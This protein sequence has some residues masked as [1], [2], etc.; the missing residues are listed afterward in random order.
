MFST[1]VDSYLILEHVNYPFFFL[2][3]L[4]VN[5]DLHIKFKCFFFF[6]WLYSEFCHLYITVWVSFTVLAY[7]SLVMFSKD[8]LS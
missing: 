6:F 3:N 5:P 2:T 1:Y 4:T 8:D 7:H